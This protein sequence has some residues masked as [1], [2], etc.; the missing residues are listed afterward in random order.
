VSNDRNKLSSLDLEVA[1]E[2]TS[3][4]IESE[5]TPNSLDDLIRDAAS[6]AVEEGTLKT[7]P[8]LAEA[9]KRVA[10]FSAI[11]RLSALIGENSNTTPQ[12]LGAFTLQECLG[13]GG[14]GRV[15]RAVNPRLGRVQAIKLLHNHRLNN[16]ESLA[17]FHQEIAALGRLDHPNI[18][19]AHHADEQ[20]G[21]PYLVMEFIDGATLSQIVR[22]LRKANKQ[23]SIQAAINLTIQ[24]AH[25]MRYAHQQGVL[26]RDLKPGN[27]L[28]DRSGVVHVSD[29]G[30]ARLINDVAVD[31][32]T[33][34]PEELTQ[35]GEVM[36]TLGF[37][38]PEQLSDSKSVDE[39]AD[40]YALGATLYFLLT[41]KE[42]HPA[43]S[44]N[45]VER[46]AAILNSP[47]PSVRDLRPDIPKKL[48]KIIT[49]LLAKNPAERVESMQEVI[50]LLTPWSGPI[51]VAEL[52]GEVDETNSVIPAVAPR[53]NR[54]GFE[55]PTFYRLLAGLGGFAFFAAVAGLI[56][57]L[58]LP[59]EGVLIIESSDPNINV[60]V[61]QIDGPLVESLEVV[62]GN[63]QPLKLRAGVW[64]IIVTGP[65]SKEVTV[66]PSRVTIG[67]NGT[68]TASIER[69]NNLSSA[70]DSIANQDS[71]L[72]A[73]AATASTELSFE[74]ELNWI[75][76]KIEKSGFGLV[77][78]PANLDDVFGWQALPIRPASGRRFPAKYTQPCDLDPQGELIGW[79]TFDHALVAN[80]NTGRIV[81]LFQPNAAQPG[82]WFSLNFS[83]SG[84]KIALSSQYG[85]FIEIRRRDG[86]LLAAWQSTT[87]SAP[88]VEWSSD[89]EH[90]LMWNDREVAIYNYLGEIQTK[91]AVKQESG[92]ILRCEFQHGNA[93]SVLLLLNDGTLQQWLTTENSSRQIA[94]LRDVSAETSSEFVQHPDGNQF[95]VSCSATTQRAE[96]WNIEGN[97]LAEVD[98]FID[99]AAWSP[100]RRYFID[101][102]RNIRDSSTLEVVKKLELAAG[103]SVELCS[104]ATYWPEDDE[105]VLISQESSDW[106]S[107]FAA[108]RRFHPVGRQ[109]SHFDF[110][111]PLEPLSATFH[112]DGQVSAF[113]SGANGPA[114][115]VRWDNRRVATE[116][117][118]TI[119][120]APDVFDVTWNPKDG[121]IFA[122]LNASQT[123]MLSPKGDLLQQFDELPSE[124]ATW[125]TDGKY[126]AMVTGNKPVI[127]LYEDRIPDPIWQSP[128]YGHISQASWSSDGN[129]LAFYSSNEN[130]TEHKVHVVNL[131]R[132]DQPIRDFDVP[133]HDHFAYPLQFSPNSKWLATCRDN[134]ESADGPHELLLIH[135]PDM[136]EYRQ[137][138]HPSHRS[139]FV[140]WAADSKSLFSGGVV[141]VDIPGNGITYVP[142][143]HISGSH[144]PVA[145]AAPDK[146]LTFSF[147]GG[148]VS[149][150][151]EDHQPLGLSLRAYS[152]HP[153]TGQSLT[154]LDNRLLFLGGMSRAYEPITCV[155]TINLGTMQGDWIGLTYDNGASLSLNSAG[156]LIHSPPDIDKYLVNIITYPGG[157][158]IPVTRKE[159]HDRASASPQEKAM[160]WASD[161]T[162]EFKDV[163]GQQ[164]K[165]DAKD[166][167]KLPSINSIASLNFSSV[168]EISDPELNHLQQFVAL[169][170]L[171]LANTP[172]TYAPNLAVLK[173]L[174]TLDLS[175]T[176]IHDL[177]FLSDMKN[178]QELTLAHVKFDSQTFQAL[179]ELE[180][181]QSL[182]LS[183]TEIDRFALLELKSLKS[184]KHLNLTGVN[185]PESDVQKLRE[186]MTQCTVQVASP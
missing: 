128:I 81:H 46:I 110:P 120:G 141:N 122:P 164:L 2:D 83:P 25:G 88:Q 115:L 160:L 102:Q 13:S 28:V 176:K 1:D 114:H 154:Q 155:G 119:A 172:I 171:S 179:C 74:N 29:L 175:A 158:T 16:S 152:A 149:K 165:V 49:R 140:V 131:K 121:R 116:H 30:L 41:G 146:W 95:L 94:K 10:D 23:L 60:S 138:V 161:V 117:H 169:T 53:L 124:T 70:V 38:A 34:S 69:Q 48:E 104:F 22:K 59:G 58:A 159:L 56:L 178:L 137:P 101:S 156:G 8:A 65:E 55:P 182:D 37:M 157:R 151:G 150:T 63:N 45:L 166:I 80:K 33:E 170:N 7:D 26:H 4:P 185:I 91:W 111:Q 40:V 6:L 43:Q 173:Q 174:T 68:T 64:E 78:Q 126:F 184:L 20:D 12:T 130:Y 5:N 32:D 162:A 132:L 47:V 108:V 133:D 66:T 86:R 112:Q 100:D 92:K 89:E 145:S 148:E 18:V 82:G 62:Q 72:P 35:D 144:F 52:W 19:A 42:V 153:N 118:Q 85:Q 177:T 99:D 3:L 27:L 168:P 180:S 9:L 125:S 106:R 93:G 87:Y 90:I 135:L 71:M 77:P 127:R 21:I 142:F 98:Q 67:R 147:R 163:D 57:R 24:A 97:R 96:L 183:H 181:L 123:A 54:F 79:T 14:M 15:F 61:R 51:P 103:D 36:G 105:I 50:E 186:Q 39:R 167:S 136:R 109:L 75:P 11:Q 17:R 44:T 76:G 31:Q 84:N 143:S 139:F 107:R 113:Y 134:L 129:W 73:P